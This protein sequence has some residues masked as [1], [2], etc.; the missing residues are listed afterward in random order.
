M[1][2]K[3]SLCCIAIVLGVSAFAKADEGMWMV[4]AIDRALEAKMKNAGLKLPAN[5]IYDENAVSL[6]DAI[7]SL[8]FSCTGSMISSDGLM[9]TNHHCAYSDVFALSTTEHNYLE[10]GFWALHFEEEKPVKSAS[11]GVYFLRKVIDVTEETLEVISQ[12]KISPKKPMS[13]R[14]ISHLLE[15]KYSELYPDNDVSLYSMF[16]GEKYYIMVYDVYHDVRLVAAPPVCLASYGGDI[17]NWEW[18]QHKG[19]F[20]LYRIY[21]AP[22]G[23]PAD[24]S[25]DNV[26]YHPKKVLK[27]STKGVK[28]GDFAMIMGYPGNTFR[29]N[30]SFE[31][32]ALQE[33][34]LPI[35][36]TLEKERMD[37]MTTWMKRN[38][39]T[40]L[41][42]SD[43]FFMLSN[44]QEIREGQV[45]CLRK[46]KV[47]EI[48]SQGRE[49]SLPASLLDSLKNA[50]EIVTPFNVQTRTLQE[51]YIRGGNLFR[52]AVMTGKNA[53]NKPGDIEKHLSSLDL[54][55]ERDIFCLNTREIFERLDSTMWGDF[56]TEAFKQYGAHAGEELWK[57]SA[58]NSGNPSSIASD[59]PV[60]KAILS[61]SVGAINER[62]ADVMSEHDLNFLRAEYKKA[63]YRGSIERGEPVYPDA[64]SSMR[65]TYGNVAS[66]SPCDAVM[67]NYYSTFAGIAQKYDPDDYNFS[68]KP[69][70]KALFD[71]KDWGRWAPKDGQ[72]RINFITNND[73]TGGNSGSPVMNSKGELVGLAFD[74]NKEGLSCD[75]YYNPDLNRCV[76]VDIRYV[77]WIL[78]KYAH[79]DRILDEIGLSNDK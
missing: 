11:D 15:K 75:Y 72:L 40:R 48:Y 38:Q 30:S 45:E 5:V 50:F 53:K 47:A 55:L 59:D 9:I 13:S 79:M 23:S 34:L 43:R 22:D 64:N 77:L 14:K 52:L 2:M 76:C 8:A 18:P 26:P 61:A 17:D 67:K 29:Y 66:M 62:K 21:T 36:A 10:D 70:I 73:I 20:A 28:E 1:T 31:L 58:L 68:L 74:G 60:V 49:K 39:H 57:R 27:I 32:R 16:A 25:E 69:E 63:V 4:N 44:V 24:Y 6:S 7:V 56:L 19:D 42:Y 35:S 3:K 12:N 51:T 37:I 71:S 33:D 41:K 46:D 54:R 65:L 78:D